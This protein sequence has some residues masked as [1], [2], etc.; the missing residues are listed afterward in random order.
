MAGQK[1]SLIDRDGPPLRTCCSSP[2]LYK[3][4]NCT[5]ITPESSSTSQTLQFK[6]KSCIDLC[7][8]HCNSPWNPVRL[9]RHDNENSTKTAITSTTVM[10]TSP[11]SSS[12]VPHTPVNPQTGIIQIRTNSQ[13]D[14]PRSQKRCRRHLEPQERIEVAYKRGRVC[15]PCR[16]RKVKVN[17]A[18]IVGTAQGIC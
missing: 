13:G 18:S 1:S 10:D 15:P 2:R 3:I 4:L 8:P 9:C 5:I 6:L 11:H 12:D 7:L 14:A 16:A 17:L